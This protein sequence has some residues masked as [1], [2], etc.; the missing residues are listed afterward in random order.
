MKEN[1]CKGISSN[2]LAKS[3]TRRHGHDKEREGSR[4]KQKR[5]LIVAQNYVIRTD[6][7]KVKIDNTQ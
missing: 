3:Y 1:N 5:F 6:Y 7:V 2:K 4:E